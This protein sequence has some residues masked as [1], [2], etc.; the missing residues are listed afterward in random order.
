MIGL[1]SEAL[2]EFLG[3]LCA[4]LVFTIGAWTVR[5]ARNRAVSRN[6][7]TTSDDE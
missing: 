6:N 3:S 1:F 2:P 5:K 7:Q 4:T